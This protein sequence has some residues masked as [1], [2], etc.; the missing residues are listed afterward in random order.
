MAGGGGGKALTLVPAGGRSDAY[1]KALLSSASVSVGHRPCAHT[2]ITRLRTFSSPV[3]LRCDDGKKYVV[4]AVQ[5]MKPV[6]GRTVIA[7]QIVGQLGHLSGAPVGNVTVLNVPPE[8]IAL[9][10]EL[11][12]MDAGPAHG[13][14]WVDNI[15]DR[16]QILCASDPLNRA[17]FSK[18]AILYGWL[19]ANDQQFFYD[20]VA[21]N[22]VISFDHGLF[23]TG[24]PWWSVADLRTAPPP[25]PDSTICTK[26]GL[27]P[28]ELKAAIPGFAAIAD[29][30]IAT[31]VA[32]IPSEW[33]IKP[34]ERVEL[35]RYI[36]DRR[37]FICTHVAGLP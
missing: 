5:Q 13:C 34:V 10:P 22:A 28:A 6:T 37:D 36:A 29:Q 1:C 20:R 4:K 32:R 2:F 9:Q 25:E 14:E 23:L 18:L 35:V 24:A 11:D 30:E 31:V 33:G 19:H 17:R 21:P 26:C 12:H 15:T 7:D 27:T 3:V 8:L 16:E